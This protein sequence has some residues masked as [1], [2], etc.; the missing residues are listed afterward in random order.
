MLALKLDILFQYSQTNNAIFWDFKFIRQ[1][2]QTLISQLLS[3]LPDQSLIC[4]QNGRGE[5]SL[6]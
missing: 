4:S 3:E 2:E 6:N 5:G 1:T